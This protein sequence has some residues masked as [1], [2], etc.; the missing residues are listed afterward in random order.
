MDDAD[1]LGTPHAPR[2]TVSIYDRP[3]WWRRRRM[4]IVALPVIAGV[5][6]LALFSWLL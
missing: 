3:P 5:V 2:A 6:S 4:W 1:S